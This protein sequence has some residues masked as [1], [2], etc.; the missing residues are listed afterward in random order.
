MTTSVDVFDD[1]VKAFFLLCEPAIPAAA[2]AAATAAAA[3][4]CGSDN[5]NNFSDESDIRL[6]ESVD[7]F[8]E[9][10]FVA[11][12]WH[13][14]ESEC[15]FGKNCKQRQDDFAERQLFCIGTF[16][17]VSIVS[18]FSAVCNSVSTRSKRRS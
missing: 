10:V 7:D 16:R 4:D 14:T 1:L 9:T 12:R 5:E 13:S 3:E 18:D 2:A 17:S 8:S 11:F 15:Y 6:Y